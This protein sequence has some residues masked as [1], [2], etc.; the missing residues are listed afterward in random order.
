MKSGYMVEKTMVMMMIIKLVI[1]LTYMHNVLFQ[2]KFI[3]KT[4]QTSANWRISDFFVWFWV[5]LVNRPD[6][7]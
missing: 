4:C 2:S 5:I 6:P 1:I 3:Y 7:V